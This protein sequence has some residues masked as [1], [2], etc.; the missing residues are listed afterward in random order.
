MTAMRQKSLIHPDQ[1]PL[2]LEREADLEALIETRVAQRCEADALRWRLQ[3]VTI[4]TLVI[5]CL[6]AA[7]A[8]AAGQSGATALR[9]SILAGG[10][11][12]AAGTLTIGLSASAAQLLA[13]LRKGK[14]P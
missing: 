14:R 4:E 9:A 5:A 8:F 11:C 1:L 2:S 7:L 12:F 3:I 6:V 10:A 13:R